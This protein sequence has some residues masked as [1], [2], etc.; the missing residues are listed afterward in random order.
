MSRFSI[1]HSALKNVLSAIHPGIWREQPKISFSKLVIAIYV[2]I[3][4]NGK[5]VVTYT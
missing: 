1:I 2:L 3:D 5:P 4:S